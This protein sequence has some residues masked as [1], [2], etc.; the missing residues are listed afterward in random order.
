MK[1][2]F[3]QACDLVHYFLCIFQSRGW[4]RI[5]FIKN[6]EVFLV[7]DRDKRFIC[8]LVKGNPVSG[9]LQMMRKKCIHRSSFVITIIMFFGRQ[10]YVGYFMFCIVKSIHARSEEHTSE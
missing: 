2:L 10:M 1:R 7:Q 4:H 9:Q 5:F 3:E 6:Q 8:R